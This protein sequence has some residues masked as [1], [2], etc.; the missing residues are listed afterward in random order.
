M[1]ISL[2][3]LNQ[4]ITLSETPEQIADLLTGCGLEV[5]HLEKIESIKGNLEGI[6]IGEVITCNKHPDAD[7]LSLTTVD[8]G[9]G[10]I[11]R[12]V[13][14]APN[15]AAKQKVVVATV[16]AT[17]YPL[18]GEAFTIKKSKIRGEI[19]EGMICAEDEIGIGHSHDGIIVLNTDLSNGTPAAA[20]FKPETDFIF[21]IGLTP[22]RADAASHLGVARDL[23]ALL[24][25]NFQIPSVDHFKEGDGPS[26][27]IE[28][29]NN[30]DCIRYSGM[31]ING[32]NITESPDWLKNRLKSIGLA[33]INNVV[34]VTNYILHDIGQPLHA[35]DADK[36]KGNKIIVKKTNEVAGF[37]TLDKQER[38]LNDSDLLIFDEEKPVAL[39]GLMGGLNSAVSQSTKNIFLESACFAPQ[40]VRKSSSNHG[41]KTDASFRFE[42]G[43]DPNI[44]K[45]ALQRAAILI[46]ELTGGTIAS[47][48]TDIYPQEVN[49]F[50]I[51][52]SY[53]NID[54]LIGKVLNRELIKEILTNLYIKVFD[55]NEKGFKVKVPPYKVDVQREADVIEEILRIYGLDNV[56]LSENIGTSYLADFPKT[57]KEKTQFDLTQM[58]AGSGFQE[59]ITNS[60]TRQSYLQKFPEITLGKEVEILNK[61]SEDLG[62]MRQTLLFSGLEVLS[63]NINRKQKDLKLFE[64]GKTYHLLEAKYIENKHLGIFISGD[65]HEES[66]INKSKNVSFHDL[67][68]TVEKILTKTKVKK[69]ES[70]ETEKKCF[71]FGLCYYNQGV[72]IVNFGLIQPSFAKAA[73][74]KQAV[75]FAD[76]NWDYILKQQNAQVFYEEISKFPEVRRDL[77][78][79]IDKKITFKEIQGLAMKTEKALLKKINV[80]DV[81]EGENIGQANKSYSVS[82]IL[83]DDKQTLTDAVI[84]KSMQKLIQVFEK[85]LGAV[86]RK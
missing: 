46:V 85:D 28:I 69:Y 27:Q 10:N 23:K 73:E 4:F 34:D 17:L 65:V 61:L 51:N 71:S 81:Y 44:T 30:A 36:L 6:V 33:P 32:V 79:V 67:T 70:R 38:K 16:G 19:S 55:E 8:I 41:L 47:K 39:A 56:E 68:L 86:I 1:V 62:A 63:Y 77:S 2:N 57:D 52:I 59:I 48:I 21:E 82:F 31:S 18:N 42:R 54:R 66:W 26:F 84:D 37:H 25:R 60:L 43:T 58:L 50:E 20:F 80:F 13:C 64:F 74:C 12:I 75:W 24:K 7:K 35:F 83:Q 9:N 45:Y 3:W 29:E 53:K 72:E 5:E 22:N 11:L 78:L 76:F 15:V 14:G 49:D 40:A